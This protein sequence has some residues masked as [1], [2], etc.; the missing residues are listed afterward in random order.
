MFVCDWS[1]FVDRSLV[2]GDS[3][4]GGIIL[5]VGSI[6]CWHNLNWEIHAEIGG[7]SRANH[8]AWNIEEASCAKIFSVSGKHPNEKDNPYDY[9]G[10][11]DDTNQT[12]T[13][14]LVMFLALKV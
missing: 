10:I 12:K 13:S 4:V 8:L 6:D 9:N 14:L 2:S 1:F 7:I 5:K 11:S 3:E